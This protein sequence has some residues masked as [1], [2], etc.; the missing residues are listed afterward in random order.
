MRFVLQFQIDIK[1]RGPEPETIFKVYCPGQYKTS[2]HKLKMYNNGSVS[3]HIRYEN[4]CDSENFVMNVAYEPWPGFFEVVNNTMVEWYDYWGL[5]NDVTQVPYDYE[6][7]KTF[8]KNYNI[9]IINWRDANGD[10]GFFNHETGNWTG[11]V[12]LVNNYYEQE[13]SSMVSSSYEN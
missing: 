3:N 8:F 6:I 7:L 2:P 5:I 12:G 1:Q 10:A 4:I 11:I 13:W 9:G